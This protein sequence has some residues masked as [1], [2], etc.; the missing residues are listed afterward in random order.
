V[1]F[2]IAALLDRLRAE[3]LVTRADADAVRAALAAQS[4][5]EMPV[6]LRIV[7]GIGAWLATGFLLGFFFGLDLLTSALA[8]IVF[9]VVLVALSVWRRRRARNDFSR[10]AAVAASFAGQGLIVFGLGEATT[11][12]SVPAM[13]AVLLSVV[14]IRL[15]PDR[16]HR[17]ISA[18]VAAHAA[19]IALTTLHLPLAHDIA[20]LLVVCAGAW[21]WR[22]RLHDRS[23]DV[24]EMLLPVGYGLV[25][26]LFGILV[27]STFASAVLGG[28][29][30][31]HRHELPFVGAPSTIAIALVLALLAYAIVRE[32]GTARRHAVVGTIVVAIALFA[33]AT[34]RS[35]GIIAGVAI[36]VLGFDRRN[37]L[38]I[39]L[40]VA[41]LFVFGA[42][43][44]YSL[45]LT[46][47]EKSGILVGSGALC[48]GAR[49]LLGAPR[50]APP[51]G[52]A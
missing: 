51:E 48:L 4:A 6:Y 17:F 19:T 21:I 8:R 27:Q 26:A 42:M 15:V 12:V 46:L 38:L 33:A 39:E 31:S 32:H 9:G 16:L 1:R 34:L 7:V 28:L 22:V 49:A 37:P 3:R 45:D 20:A 5:D 18:V 40:A 50:A 25:V 47:L 41:Y 44:Y 23:D 2:T 52:I 35:P 30:R 11:D 29:D 14:L 10:H 36:L 24:D 43:Y 13:V